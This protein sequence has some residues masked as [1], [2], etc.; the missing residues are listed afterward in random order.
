[1]SVKSMSHSGPFSLYPIFLSV[2]D[3]KLLHALN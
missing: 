2:S 3:Q 1:M